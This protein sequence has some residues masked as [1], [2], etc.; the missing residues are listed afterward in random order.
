[1]MANAWAEMTARAHEG[2]I[3]Q[4]ANLE[5]RLARASPAMLVRSVA[6]PSSLARTRAGVEGRYADVVV[7]AKPDNGVR[8]AIFEGALFGSGRP[9]IVAPLDWRK[10][11]LGRNIAVGWNGA[12]EAA[13]ALQ[14][15][16]PL[17]EQADRITIITVD[18]KSHRSSHG[19][20]IAAHL[21]R[22]GLKPEVRNVDAR[23]REEGKA[24]LDECAASGADLLVLGGYGHPRMQEVAFGGVTREVLRSSSIPLF[25]SH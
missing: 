25:M 16:G 8:Q 4:K 14:D 15:A 12:R 9:V 1:M 23:G 19:A 24:L 17:L 22:R 21:A 2:Y 3:D 7:I 20:D 10:G 6:V 5:A 18:A 13:R 11:A